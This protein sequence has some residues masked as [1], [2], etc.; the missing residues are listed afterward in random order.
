ML[1][2]M[3][4]CYLIEG[5]QVVSGLDEERLVDPGVVYVVGSCCHQSQEHLLRA[6]VLCQLQYTN[7][8]RFALI[9][10]HVENILS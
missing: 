3:C 9:A 4:L 10:Q 7:G 5:C 6:Q 1:Q 8:G 2:H